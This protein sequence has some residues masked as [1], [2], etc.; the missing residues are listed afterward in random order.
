MGRRNGQLVFS[1][2]EAFGAAVA[3]GIKKVKG[4]LDLALVFSDAVETCG[5]AMFTTN[6][7]AAAPVLVGYAVAE[8]V[9]LAAAAWVIRARYRRGLAPSRVGTRRS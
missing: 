9:C 5:A 8:L 4:A 3:A 7:A 2:E 1:K 6:C